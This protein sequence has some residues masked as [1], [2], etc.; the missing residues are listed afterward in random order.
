MTLFII[1]S[2]E[3]NLGRFWHSNWNRTL[4]RTHPVI[5]I[6]Q[7]SR[8]TMQVLVCDQTSCRILHNLVFLKKISCH[9]NPRKTRFCQEIQELWVL[10]TRSWQE[11][12]ER[13]WQ[14][15]T[16]FT[17]SL[18]SSWW[19]TVSSGAMT[20]LQRWLASSGSPKWGSV[21]IFEVTKS[22]KAVIPTSHLTTNVLQ[23]CE[24]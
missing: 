12:K 13:T 22:D 15:F 3:I 11:M 16:F 20:C 7:K 9:G 24:W 14:E 4:T 21:V 17:L 10:E 5:R 8:T 6:L 2:F 18:H 1:I 19:K 23:N